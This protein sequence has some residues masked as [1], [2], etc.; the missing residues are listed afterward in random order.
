MPGS[1][2]LLNRCYKGHEITM[3]GSSRGKALSVAMAAPS[4]E[5]LVDKIQYVIDTVHVCD[6]DGNSLL[7]S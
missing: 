7:M 4:L 6:A 1:T 5:E 3:D 2:I